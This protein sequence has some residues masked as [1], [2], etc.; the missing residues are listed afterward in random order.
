[1]LL[2]VAANLSAH[3][4]ANPLAA[5]RW[6]TRPLIVVAADAAAVPPSF[7]EQKNRAAFAERQV[8]VFTIIGGVGQ[9]DGKSLDQAATAAMLA[10]LGLRPD[11]PTTMVLIGKDGGVK[12]RQPHLS[13]E[14]I[15]A[16]IDRMPMRR[17][18]V[19]S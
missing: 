17:A 14:Q 9:R 8:V 19:K 4:A 1:L 15:L 18:E 7:T 12:L 10:T 5:E 2:A 13:V 16:T 11:G 6:N 3:A